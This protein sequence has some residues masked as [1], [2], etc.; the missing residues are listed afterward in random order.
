MYTKYNARLVKAGKIS[1]TM[2]SSVGIFSKIFAMI[3]TIDFF[4]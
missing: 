2:H 1:F 4:V 3:P